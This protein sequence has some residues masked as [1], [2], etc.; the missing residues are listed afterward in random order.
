VEDAFAVACD[1][2]PGPVFVECA[3]DLLYDEA[4][5]RKWYGNASGPARSV[6]DLLSRLYK[7]RQLAK[8]FAGNAT[9]SPARARNV[10]TPLVRPASVQK[11]ARS[12]ARASR[13]LAVIGSQAPAVGQDA[14]HIAAA[15]ARLGVP[16]YLSGMARGLLGR[17]HPLQLHHQRR[18]ALR[19]ADCIIL[20]GVPCDFR[21]DYGRH[22]RR[23]STLIAANRSRTEARLNRRPDVA[24]IGDAGLFLEQLA[25]Q[26]GEAGARYQDW[27]EELHARDA[28]REA[29]IEQQ[30]A[31]EGEFVNP[32]AL[33]RAIDRAAGENSTR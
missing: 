22:I 26:A 18:Q 16:A 10:A 17:D 2:V 32:V 24:A 30:A 5:V 3:I 13:P 27:L 28:R 31:A 25:D 8:L 15:I 23:S 21:M 9:A 7:N 20:V 6:A 29:E 12:L 4:S 33:L 11:A 19:E 1:G 14:T